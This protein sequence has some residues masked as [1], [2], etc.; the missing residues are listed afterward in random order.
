MLFVDEIEAIDID[1]EFDF[2]LAEFIFDKHASE[3]SE[4]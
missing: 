3:D 4:V 1:T 2:S